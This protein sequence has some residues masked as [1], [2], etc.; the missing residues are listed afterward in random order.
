ME[1]QGNMP[2]LVLKLQYM[3]CQLNLLQAHENFVYLGVKPGNYI[4][5]LMSNIETIIL[6]D[7]FLTEYR[8][9]TFYVDGR[10]DTTEITPIKESGIRIPR[11]V[12]IDVSGVHLEHILKSPKKVTDVIKTVSLAKRYGKAPLKLVAI[13][14][15][16]NMKGSW[17]KPQAVESPEAEAAGI[18]AMINVVM[19]KCVDSLYPH[20]FFLI[21]LGTGANNCHAPWFPISRQ[22]H[23]VVRHPKV[24]SD[25][26]YHDFDEH[27]REEDYLTHEP[28]RWNQGAVMSQLEVLIRFLNQTNPGLNPVWP[29]PHVREQRPSLM[30]NPSPP[31]HYD[32][33]PRK[34]TRAGTHQGRGR[35]RRPGRP[36][37]RRPN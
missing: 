26:I 36:Y 2:R 25:I 6:T 9:T 30:R 20:P 18:M 7:D 17:K 29:Q 10:A 16:T 21:C 31:P 14:G 35:L 24:F 19:R 15:K 37:G 23:Q 22:V 5:E 33:P 12:M 27:L 8:C 34:G 4:P 11:S 3:Q 32:S 1:E 13:L 28:F